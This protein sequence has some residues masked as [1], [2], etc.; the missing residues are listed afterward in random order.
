MRV[1]SLLTLVVVAAGQVACDPCTGVANCDN[2][3][4]L[5]VD[6]QIVD[7]ITGAGLDGVRIDVIRVGGV[8][9]DVDSMQSVTT[10]GG[11]WRVEFEPRTAGA[12]EVDIVVSPP[13]FAPYRVPRVVLQTR[14]RGGDANVL[15][16]WVP[17]PYFSY[18]AEF[19]RNGTADERIDGAVVEF[20]RTGGVALRGSGI[21]G[22]AFRGSTDVAGRITIFPTRE[23]AVFPVTFG[24]VVGE[25][26]VTFGPTN[27]TS[28]VRD[29]TLTPT[30]VYRRQRSIYRAG[31]GPGA[32]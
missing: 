3:A 2:G 11:H 18:A 30:P 6:G 17:E 28:V 7:P 15:D 5:A 16:P 10:D 27:G 32:P 12:V 19:Y 9:I 31:V 25:F 22:G 4:Y 14:A 29:V 23:N 26:L 13:G 21:Q 24:D 20:R 1:R 8:A